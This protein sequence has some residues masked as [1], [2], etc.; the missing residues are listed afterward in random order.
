M[1]RYREEI[2][3]PVLS[4]HAHIHSLSDS[5]SIISEIIKDVKEL[6]MDPESVNK[7]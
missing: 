5:G 4:V 1:R 3:R 2:E 6:T 7:E